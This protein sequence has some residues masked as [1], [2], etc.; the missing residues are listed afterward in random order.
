MGRDFFYSLGNEKLVGILKRDF[1]RWNVICFA[2]ESI[3]LCRAE[4]QAK[5]DCNF[6]GFRV[7]GGGEGSRC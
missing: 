3:E 4:R 6:Q 2:N 5:L 1:T 7:K